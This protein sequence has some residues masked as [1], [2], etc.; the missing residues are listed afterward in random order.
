M[1]RQISTFPIETGLNAPYGARCFLTAINEVSTKIIT[2]SLN[3]PYGA[4][5][6]LTA[7]V[8]AMS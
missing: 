7:S 2:G 3:A 4:W 5:C 8:K 1:L 6:F